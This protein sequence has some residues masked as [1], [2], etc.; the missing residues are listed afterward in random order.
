MRGSVK[1]FS[2]KKGFGFITP[3]DQSADVFV[4]HSGIVAVGR[5]SLNDGDDVTFDVEIDQKH[6]KPSAINVRK[7]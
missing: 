1:W 4:H 2:D 7:V 3:E 5:R 6:R